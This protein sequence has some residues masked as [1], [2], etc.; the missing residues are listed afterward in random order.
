MHLLRHVVWRRG[1]TLF[2][3]RVSTAACCRLR[4]LRCSSCATVDASNTICRTLACK[5][6]RRCARAAL[7]CRMIPPI[8]LQSRRDH[9][10]RHTVPRGRNGSA[11]QRGDCASDPSAGSARRKVSWSSSGPVGFTIATPWCS[12]RLPLLSVQSETRIASSSSAMI[13]MA[14][15]CL[16]R[17]CALS[18]SHCHCHY[19]RTSKCV[20]I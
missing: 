5:M 1:P 18:L 19:L 3:A 8:A 4:I 20:E 10:P 15:S 12:V 7:L 13:P 6:G 2:G 17:S 11:R 16:L 14:W 9:A